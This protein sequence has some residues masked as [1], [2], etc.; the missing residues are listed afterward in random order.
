[1]AKIGIAGFLHETN[2]FAASRARFAT[3]VEADA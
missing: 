2:A 1:V 3:F